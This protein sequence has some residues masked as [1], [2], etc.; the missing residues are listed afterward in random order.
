MC[1]CYVT[2]DTQL[3]NVGDC[4]DPGTPTNGDKI[5]TGSMEGDTVYYTCDSGFKLSGDV[6]RTCQSN[7]QWS[8][9]LPKCIRTFSVAL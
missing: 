7:G 3:H 6:T 9:T 2:C 5:E 1:A 4:G 8:G